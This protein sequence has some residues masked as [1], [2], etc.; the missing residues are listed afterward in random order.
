MNLDI[1]MHHATLNVYHDG[2]HRRSIMKLGAGIGIISVL[3]GVALMLVLFAGPVGP[4]GSSYGGTVAKKNKEAKEQVQQFNGRDADGRR[5]SETL[6]LVQWPDD[7]SFRGALVEAIE[8]GQIAQTHFGL[9][10]GD[11]IKLI[12]PQEVGGMIIDSVDVTNDMLDDA[13]ARGFP[14]EVLRDNQT[15]ELQGG[16]PDNAAGAIPGI[17]GLPPLK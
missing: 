4:G 16:T 12:G 5:L 9:Q 1:R 14:L 6:T 13:Y 3:L 7:R 11:V 17:P 8:D 10:P 2:F 15:I